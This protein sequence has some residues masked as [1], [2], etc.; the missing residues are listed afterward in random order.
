MYNLREYLSKQLRSGAPWIAIWTSLKSMRFFLLCDYVDCIWVDMELKTATTKQLALIYNSVSLWLGSPS[1]VSKSSSN[2]LI[3]IFFMFWRWPLSRSDNWDN[4][5]EKWLFEELVAGLWYSGIFSIWLSSIQR[6][7]SF[8]QGWQT[9]LTPHVMGT[10]LLH[11]AS[12]QKVA[13]HFH[14]NEAPR[15]QSRWTGYVSCRLR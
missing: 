2:F 15:I 6:E 12:Q 3:D 1:P 14:A 7:Q 9:H 13:R 5:E 4:M 10:K 8:S 11:H